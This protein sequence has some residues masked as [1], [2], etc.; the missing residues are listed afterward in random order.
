M[1]V[2]NQLAAK[3]AEEAQL[4]AQFQQVSAFLTSITNFSTSASEVVSL[5]SDHVDIQTLGRG[6][7]AELEQPIGNCQEG[8]EGAG[9]AKELQAKDKSQDRGGEEKLASVAR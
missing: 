2:E 3:Q 6:R 8:G 4:L 5:T 7:T 1:L 9:A